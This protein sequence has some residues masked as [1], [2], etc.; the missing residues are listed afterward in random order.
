MPF[1]I[2]VFCA[3][4]VLMLL[5]SAFVVSRQSVAPSEKQLEVVLRDIGH[6]LLLR[7]HDSTSRVLPIE[8]RGERTYEI[9]FQ[10]TLVF[11][12]DT[13][14]AVVQRRLS[15]THALRNYIVNVKD[16]FN[17]TTIFAYEINPQKEDI[18][19]CAGREQA[20]GCYRIEI[21][22]LEPPRPPYGWLALLLLPLA[23]LGFFLFR[24]PQTAP[25]QPQIPE[26][27]PFIALGQYAFYPEKCTLVFAGNVLALSE[28]EARA[29]LLFTQNMNQVVER[30]RLLKELWEDEGLVVISRNIDVLVSKL[31]KKLA[32]DS[33]LKIL[34]VP[35][36]GYKLVAE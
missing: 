12:P 36:R 34:T 23:V 8:K 27:Q 20:A 14:V 15:R 11:V 1:R 9:S 31:R 6:Q 4:L 32:H 35:K 30:E 33:A 29:L 21:E 10:R 19:P 3:L 13:L 2:V 26:N 24:K 25:F 18:I 5:V 22:F 28:K 7:A 16:C 17:R